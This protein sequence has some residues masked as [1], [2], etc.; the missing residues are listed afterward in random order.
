MLHIIA[1]RGIGGYDTYVRI[2]A[3][4]DAEGNKGELIGRSY[5]TLLLHILQAS[6]R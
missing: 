6:E 4:T 5:T 1:S 2:P 3:M